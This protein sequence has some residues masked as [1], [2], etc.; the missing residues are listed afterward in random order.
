MQLT[1]IARGSSLLTAL[2]LLALT[3]CSSNV[4]RV[5]G[6]VVENGQPYELQGGECVQIDIVSADPDMYPPLALTTYSKP[7]GTFAA[8]PNDGTGRGLPPGK[9]KLKLNRE[10]TSLKKKANGKLF[11]ESHP[12]EVV[13]GAPVRLTIDLATGTITP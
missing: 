1:R 7:D 6:Q 9:Y 11:K 2:A 10:V 8:D 4:V 5:T 13:Q 12:F 3:G